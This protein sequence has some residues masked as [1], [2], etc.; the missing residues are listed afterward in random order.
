MA[1]LVL[2]NNVV[3]AS[4][5]IYAGTPLTDA[6]QQAAVQAVGGVLV[7]PTANPAVAAAAALVAGFAATGRFTPEMWEAMML[8]ALSGPGGNASQ[9]FEYS[10]TSKFGDFAGL[11]AGVKVL[12]YNIGPVLPYGARLMALPV[13]DGW[14]GFDDPTHAVVTAKVGI[15]AGGVELGASTAVDVTTGSGFPKAF[16]AG[17]FDGYGLAAAAQMRVR[18]GSTVDLNTLTAGAVTVRCMVAFLS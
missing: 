14:T 13:A 3:L 18:I 17:A 10:A 16:G 1:K 12:D 11:A 6:T 9:T 4:G 2:L 15:T 5:A 7:D 8:A